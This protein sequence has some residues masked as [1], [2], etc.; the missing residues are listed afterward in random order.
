MLNIARRNAAAAGLGRLE[1]RHGDIFETRLADACADLVVV[2]QVLHYLSDPAAA[3]AEAARLVQPGGKLLIV[4]FA[5][6]GL[7]FL[8]EAHQH[9]RLGFSD[10]EIGR[11][12]EAAGLSGLEPLALPPAKDKGLTVKIWTAERIAQSDRSAA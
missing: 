12:F 3:L 1:L 2:H 7:E 10:A 11:W 6:H 5:P 9:R 8:R 4:D